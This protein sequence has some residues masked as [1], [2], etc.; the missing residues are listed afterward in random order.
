M[1]VLDYYSSAVPCI[2][3]NNE[4]NS[5]ILKIILVHGFVILMKIL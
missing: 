5:S 1:K 3:S 2:M 4:N